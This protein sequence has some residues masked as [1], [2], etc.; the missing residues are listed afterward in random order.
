[1]EYDAS[2]STDEECSVGVGDRTDIAQAGQCRTSWQYEGLG[3]RLCQFP[4]Y[5]NGKLHDRCIMLEE[6]DAILPVFRCP[7]LN[8]VNKI[9]GINAWTYEDFDK[10]MKYGGL[11]ISD[12]TTSPPTVDP[13]VS[14]ENC[15]DI[16]YGVFQPCKNNC[17]GGMVTLKKLLK[18]RG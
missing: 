9:N 2:S 14:M 8:T 10:Q 16:G 6:D 5:W 15:G 3:E 7:I 11:C 17:A 4:F 12:R 1:M 13:A 18:G